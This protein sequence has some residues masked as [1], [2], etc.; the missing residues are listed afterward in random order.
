MEFASEDKVQ[1]RW[2]TQFK[3]G[4]DP[5]VGR[6]L[7]KTAEINVKNKKPKDPVG[8]VRGSL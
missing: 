4:L 3:T 7:N 8:K 6:G 2:L 1:W 5:S